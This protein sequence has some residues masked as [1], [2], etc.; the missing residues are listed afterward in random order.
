M[1][2][3]CIYWNK[4]CVYSLED[5]Q[6]ELD[7]TFEE[8]KKKK[9]FTVSGEQIKI[10]FL[11]EQYSLIEDNK[12]TYAKSGKIG[13]LKRWHPDLYMK[14]QN[15]E[16]SLANALAMATQSTPDSNPIAPLSPPDS[17]PIATQSQNIADKDKDKDKEIIRAKNA[18]DCASFEKFWNLYDKKTDKS[19]AVK[20]WNRLS[21]KDR[22]E[23][24]AKVADY[25]K[26][27]PDPQY[28]K[29]P[30]TYLNGKN[31][32]D[33]LNFVVN[34]TAKTEKTGAT[35]QTF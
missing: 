3:C 20:A 9:M 24:M 16:L 26:A 17:N 11:D 23:C 30:T 6:I 31:W 12:S 8:L 13:N 19:R 29:N 27:T 33:E 21:Q 28:R 35:Y 14:Y 10:K 7:D 1:N 5:A 25:V 2:L 32:N 22:D 18:L 4:D 34:G 15:G